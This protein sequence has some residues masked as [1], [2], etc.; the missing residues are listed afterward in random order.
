[1]ETKVLVSGIIFGTLYFVLTIVV[2]WASWRYIKRGGP[3]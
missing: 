1:M 2:M 3:K